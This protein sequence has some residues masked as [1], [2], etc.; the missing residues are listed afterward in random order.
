MS[1]SPFSTPE[2]NQPTEV[3]YVPQTSG[4]PTGVTVF[5]ILNILFGIT[6]ILGVIFSAA[7]M[8]LGDN[9][10]FGGP[11]PVFEVMNDNP[12]YKIYT[13]VM[14]FVGLG[15]AIVLLM[16]GVGLFKMRPW[17]RTLALVYA[18]Y[19]IVAT[20]IGNVANYFFIFK[21]IMEQAVGE[22]GGQELVIM[23]GI[24]GGV[25]GGC[26]A[27]ILP[28]AILI[29]FMRPSVKALFAAQP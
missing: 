9:L 21:P 12:T 6:G 3:R 8:L 15:F 10:Q 28:I 25:V 7:M 1:S 13:I 11:N 19:A 17:A 20:I 18:V 24:I 27:L 26:I 5:A 2:P 16:S 29:Y 23:S 14:S 22:G 4:R